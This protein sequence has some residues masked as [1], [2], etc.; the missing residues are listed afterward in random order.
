MDSQIPIK[1]EEVVKAI[2]PKSKVVLFGS[3][4][5]GEAHAESDWDFLILTSREVS[6]ELVDEILA[7]LYEVELAVEQ[8]ISSVIEN[9]QKWEDYLNSEFY[10]N[11]KD[12]GI[13]VEN[14]KA[15]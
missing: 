7:K 4:A 2:D 11:V 14:M 8:V 3:R 13:V 9:Q 10:Q 15:A 6:P 5:R 12:H 1:V